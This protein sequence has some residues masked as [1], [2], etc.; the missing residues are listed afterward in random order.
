MTLARAAAIRRVFRSSKSQSPAERHVSAQTPLIK[1][2]ALVPLQPLLLGTCRRL[3]CPGPCLLP[4]QRLHPRYF[5]LCRKASFIKPRP[6]A[7]NEI[8]SAFTESWHTKI[9]GIKTRWVSI[10]GRVE[11]LA[12]EKGPRASSISRLSLVLEPLPGACRTARA[13]RVYGYA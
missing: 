7:A 5:I 12:L 1:T 6:F 9:A 4:T 3:P 11:S 2:L 10:A 13:T 8:R